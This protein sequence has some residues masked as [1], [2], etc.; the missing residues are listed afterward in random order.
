MTRI[1]FRILHRELV[2]RLASRRSAVVDATNLTAAAR[3]TILR[4]ASLAAVPA[5]AIV[6]VPP[7]DE[8]HVRNAARANGVVPA[9]VVD[10]QLAAAAALGATAQQVADRLIVEGFAAVHVLTSTEAI[11]AAVI[12]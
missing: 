6:L 12:D 5:I 4:R 1:A 2:K 3:S 11:D 8:V 10:R 7:A 9:E